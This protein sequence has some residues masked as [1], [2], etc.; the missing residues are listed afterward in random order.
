MQCYVL[1][2]VNM[3]I[4]TLQRNSVLIAHLLWVIKKEN[5]IV[6]FFNH[7]GFNNILVCHLALVQETHILVCRIFSVCFC[8]GMHKKDLI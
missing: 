4:H 1:L 5:K 7:N 3:L 2:S 6:L 8:F